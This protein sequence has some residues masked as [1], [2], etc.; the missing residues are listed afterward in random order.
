MKF[1]FIGDI[2]GNPG[3]RA[4]S[5]L[6]PV[7]RQRHACDDAGHRH[8]GGALMRLSL[9]GKTRRAA[10]ASLQK[11][12]QRFLR[13]EWMSSPPAIIFGIKK[14]SSP[15]SKMSHDFCGQ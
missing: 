6:V 8:R 13:L 2:V 15:C 11:Q 5:A 9:M 12:R 4:L 14:R 7:L 3:R 1:L 10:P